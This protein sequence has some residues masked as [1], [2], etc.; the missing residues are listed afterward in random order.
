M[1]NKTRSSYSKS[2]KS[3]KTKEDISGEDPYTVSEINNLINT[4]IKKKFKNVTVK[5]EISSVSLS[6]RHTYM[7]MKDD[8]SLIYVN[9]WNNRIEFKQGDE[10]KVNGKIEYYAKNGRLSMIGNT[11]E[12][13]GKGS[14]YAK[15]EKL[16]KKYKKK[17][18]FDNKKEM[19]KNIKNVGVVTAK[20]GAALQDFLKVMK[21]KGFDGNVYV[22]NAKV[23]GMHC[24]ESVKNGIEFFNNGIDINSDDNSNDNSNDNSES[25]NESSSG[26]Y[27]YAYVTDE[28]N[29]DNS[30]EDNSS[31]YEYNYVYEDDESKL[32]VDIIVVTRGGGSFEDLCGFSEVPVIEAIHSSKIFVL[33]AVGHEVDTTIADHVANYCVGTPSMAGGIVS[34]EHDEYSKL[35]NETMINVLQSK[36][37]LS[38][39]LRSIITTLD[40]LIKIDPRQEYIERIDNIINFNKSKLINRMNK[41]LN[42]L[43]RCEMKLMSNDCTKLL[44]KGFMLLIDEEGDIVNNENVFDRNLTLMLSSGKYKVNIS[45]VD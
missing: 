20:E 5:G 13:E 38:N 19:P 32:F 24:P 16:K 40:R 35:F 6:G 44:E 30:N 34:K 37:K 25:D 2:S 29:S 11:I 41:L 33:S 14:I 42:K 10:V 45:R 28:D 4:S 15:Y 1:K 9:F 12:L 17:G 8:Y 23:Q 7:T 26:E 39:K 3:S 18:Y 27:Q 22:Y 31:E 36:T 43:N 21:N